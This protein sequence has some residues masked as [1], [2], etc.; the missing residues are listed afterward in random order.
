[1][2]MAIRSITEYKSFET[3][4]GSSKENYRKQG[5]YVYSG[6]EFDHIKLLMD[7]NLKY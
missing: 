6:S 1:M 7:Y 2:D 4:K 3:T 5:N